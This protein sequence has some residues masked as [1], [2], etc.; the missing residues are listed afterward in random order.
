[1]QSVMQSFIGWS[2]AFFLA[3]IVIGGI[4]RL[5]YAASCHGK[6]VYIPGD[7][8]GNVKKGREVDKKNTAEIQ[9]E[10]GLGLIETPDFVVLGDEVISTSA[11][12]EVVSIFDQMSENYTNKY[13]GDADA[14]EKLAN[15]ER[16]IEA[17]RGNSHANGNNGTIYHDSSLPEG[18]YVGKDVY[19]NY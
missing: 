10:A 15:A 19:K 8:F 9:H 18:V 5:L 7:T 17:S 13:E 2:A 1:M 3:C 6:G 11:S 16:G 14:S 12:S 4:I